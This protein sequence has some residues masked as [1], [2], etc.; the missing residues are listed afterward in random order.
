MALPIRQTSNNRITF[1]IDPVSENW[2]KIYFT[3][4]TISY[5]ANMVLNGDGDNT[6]DWNVSGATQ[7]GDSWLMS[8]PNNYN[9]SIVDGTDGFSDRAQRVQCKTAV[10]AAYLYCNNFGI[11]NAN[12]KTYRLWLQYRSSHSISILQLTVYTSTGVSITSVPSNTGNATSIEFEWESAENNFLG[13][14]FLL[15][16][17]GDTGSA[18]WMEIDKIMVKEVL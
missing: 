12:G 1:E 9:L 18:V 6:T 4:G 16:G 7:L 2:H 8:N 3:G 11:T 10:G 5:G 14:F 17:G 13:M 15:S